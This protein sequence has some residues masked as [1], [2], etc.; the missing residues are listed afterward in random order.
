MDV[1]TS[2]SCV[3]F[4][5]FDY[6]IKRRRTGTGDFILR[7]T[8]A[9]RD[10]VE[11]N[12]RCNCGKFNK[13]P[14]LWWN[15]EC[16]A[17]LFQTNG[18]FLSSF[19]APLDISTEESPVTVKITFTILVLPTVINKHCT[20]PESESRGAFLSLPGSELLHFVSLAKLA[21]TTSYGKLEI[22]FPPRATTYLLGKFY[23]TYTS[24]ASS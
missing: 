2:I 22:H 1:H 23:A 20:N 11:C 10:S 19:S 16:S 17:L 21:W 3:A 15:N 6:Y 8:S 12:A 18:C 9:I 4:L 13:F 7:F 5:F 14:R 24:F